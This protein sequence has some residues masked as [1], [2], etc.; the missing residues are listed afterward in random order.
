M[1][2]EVEIRDIKYDINVKNIKTI[3]NN[4]GIE[5]ERLSFKV[6]GRE[7]ELE[8]NSQGKWKYKEF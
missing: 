3:L 6:D 5:D 4:F 1:K 7:I 2:V 8:F